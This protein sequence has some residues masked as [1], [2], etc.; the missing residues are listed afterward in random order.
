MKDRRKPVK[1]TDLRACDNCGGPVGAIFNVVQVRVAVVRAEAVRQ[2]QGGVLA[3]KMSVEL[4]EVMGV[5]QD[6]DNAVVVAGVGEVGKNMKDL[7]KSMKDLVT[8][9]FLCQ[10]CMCEPVVLASLVEKRAEAT[11]AGSDGG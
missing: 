5:V 7:A 2:A 4:S 3:F 8:E 11:E 6:A 1:L 9:V 10:G